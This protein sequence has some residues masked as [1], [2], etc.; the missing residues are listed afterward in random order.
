MKTVVGPQPE[1]EKALE[2]RILAQGFG[3]AIGMTLFADR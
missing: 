1:S 2:R 3:E